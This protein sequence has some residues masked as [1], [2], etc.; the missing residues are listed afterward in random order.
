MKH[1]KILSKKSKEILFSGILILSSFLL[2]CS[3]LDTPE[4]SDLTSKKYIHDNNRSFEEALQI[5][6]SS[7]NIVN[8]NSVTRSNSKRVIS[9]KDTKTYRSQPITRS[10]SGT[11]DTLMY[12]FN[13][14]GNQGFA[15][16][17]ATKY[18][19]GLIA[20]TEQ[21]Y[22]DP[23]I[24]STNEG[25]NAFMD[26]TKDYIIKSK[27]RGGLDPI[28]PPGFQEFKDTTIITESWIG[29]FVVVKW[30]QGYP[31]NIDCSNGYSG[32]AVT[33]MA[34]LMSYYEQPTYIYCT[35]V[36]PYEYYQLNWTSLKS[37]I[38]SNHVGTCPGVS[39]ETHNLIGRLCRQLGEVSNTQY[40][41]DGSFTTNNNTK[42]TLQ[43][44]GY[45][46]GSWS[47]YSTSS[48]DTNLSNN[49]IVMIRGDEDISG[50][51]HMWLIDGRYRRITD[52]YEWYRNYGEV[53]WILRRHT[54]IDDRYYHYNWG[55]S[56][57]NNGYFSANIFNTQNEYS[58]DSPN[59][60]NQYY[61]YK[62]NVKI[63]PVYY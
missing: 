29:P 11:N 19:E 58:F 42:N 37:H 60:N 55:Y 10:E 5:A 52:Y 30:G 31:E 50:N 62:N 38:I 40:Q 2:A 61:N 12:V 4:I 25:F 15:V 24:R 14:E 57:E 54:T 7:I 34:Q 48:I 53:D 49:H 35:Y 8:A 13:F 1:K 63:L 3:N 6:Q 17:S 45:Q 56:G 20:V 23:E 16:V 27:N 32:C 39:Q 44:Y 28:L 51:G 22:Y 26:L 9:I 47:T 59:G 36:N 41:L 33:A 46:T 21:G 43:I 18:T